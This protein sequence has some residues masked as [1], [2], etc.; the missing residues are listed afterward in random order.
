MSIDTID[1]K[2][3]IQSNLPIEFD[4]I[5]KYIDHVEKKSQQS[6]FIL[7]IPKETQVK[8]FEEVEKILTK[9]VFLTTGNL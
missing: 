9:Q 7:L 2:L 5:I 8:G 6:T 1:I 4:V 3:L